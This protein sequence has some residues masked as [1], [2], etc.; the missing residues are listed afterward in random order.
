ME[1]KEGHQIPRLPSGSHVVVNSLPPAECAA[2][3]V[4]GG[5]IWQAAP[6]MCRWIGSNIQAFIGS[7][8]LEL[9]SGTGACGLFC[10]GCGAS[11]VVCTEGTADAPQLLELI[12]SSIQLNCATWLAESVVEVQRLD[13]GCEPD[14]LPPGPF[15]WV[16]AS[17]CVY[18]DDEFDHVELCHTVW[19]LLQGEAVPRVILALQHGIPAVSNS[20]SESSCT[21]L[22]V[23]TT[24][25]QLR[26]AARRHGLRIGS[27]LPHVNIGL[28]S[29][30]EELLFPEDDFEQ[31]RIFLVELSLDERD[32]FFQP[33]PAE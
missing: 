24:L 23:D 10:A 5:K 13:W 12:K 28:P 26:W 3:I 16:L 7:S 19:H 11:R 31:G 33:I 29:D 25:Q 1:A 30:S 15:D 6:E 4:L 8:V 32:F 18:G 27:V 14:L 21:R 22:C 20:D 17:D 2:D 9:G